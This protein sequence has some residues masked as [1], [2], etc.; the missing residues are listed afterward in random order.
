MKLVFNKIQNDN[1]F[2]LNGY[3]KTLT[4]RVKIIKNDRLLVGHPIR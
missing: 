4:N 3:K 2:R 1:C